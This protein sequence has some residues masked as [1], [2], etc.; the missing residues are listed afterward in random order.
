MNT[1]ATCSK[2]G[3]Q[4]TGKWYKNNT[5]VSCYKR[6]PRKSKSGNPCITCAIK[7]HSRWYFG[8]TCEKCYRKKLK[9]NKSAAPCRHCNT[10]E[11]T[12][13]YR[14]P[15]C[16]SCYG[17]TVT[18]H[19]TGKGCIDCGAEQSHRW[20]RDLC[21]WC[22]RKKPES[23]FSVSKAQAKFKRL[24][25]SLTFKEY[26]VLLNAKCHYCGA[27]LLLECGIG[28]D[29]INNH[30]GYTLENVL[31]CCGVCNKRRGNW[32]TV[33]QMKFVIK[34]LREFDKDPL[35][36]SYLVRLS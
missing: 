25:W 1:T 20:H 13:W 9:P 14:G 35:K 11:S 32:L 33:E 17:R 30:N 36:G 22:Y 5:C 23:R 4:K 6:T 29:R 27:G 15:V 16:H 7:E 2:C 18:R 3:N 8:P 26:E 31:P 19:H 28:L 10:L 21:D 34:A 12:Q 24:E